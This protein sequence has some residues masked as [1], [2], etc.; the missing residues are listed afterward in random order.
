LKKQ[1]ELNLALKEGTCGRIIIR[2]SGGVDYHGEERDVGFLD[3]FL[4][5]N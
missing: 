1:Q 4:W 5:K 3:S 2:Q